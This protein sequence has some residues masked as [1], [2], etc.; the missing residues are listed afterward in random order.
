LGDISIEL[1]D[2]EEAVKYW[3]TAQRRGNSSSELQ[4]KIETNQ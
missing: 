2:T 4:N 1:G 3:K